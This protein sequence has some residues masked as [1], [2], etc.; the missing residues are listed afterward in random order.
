MGELFKKKMDLKKIT[1]IVV[2]GI[3][4]AD[5]PDFCDS[6]IESAYYDGKPMTEEQLEELNENKDFVY[7]CIINKL[8]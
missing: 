1:D 2:E 6:F 7:E 4:K 3:D 5:Y 8:Y